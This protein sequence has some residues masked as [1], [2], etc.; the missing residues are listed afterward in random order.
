[1]L[2]KSDFGLSKYFTSL[3]KRNF[4]ENNYFYLC[5][6]EEIISKLFVDYMNIIRVVILSIPRKENKKIDIFT[7][8]VAHKS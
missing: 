3:H 8:V 2:N 1:M 4:F 7:S 6:E 5:K